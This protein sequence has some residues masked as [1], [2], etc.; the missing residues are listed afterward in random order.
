[1]DRPVLC[2]PG[3]PGLAAATLEEL[4]ALPL[5]RQL[6]L[7]E[8]R[9]EGLGIDGHARDLERVRRNLGTRVIDLLGHSYGSLVALTYAATHPEHVGR[10]VLVATATRLSEEQASL[11]RTELAAHA[12]EPWFEDALDA[13][14]RQGAGDYE[15]DEELAE[16]FARQ[17]PF[18]FANPGQAEA[19]F[20]ARISKLPMSA[21]AFRHFEQS[22]RATF[23]LR[24]LLTRVRARVLVVVGAQDPVLGPTSA[25][26][27]AD[28]IEGAWLEVIEDAGHFPWIEQ[29]QRFEE[30]VA[31]FLAEP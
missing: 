2:L 9:P 30:V 15:S 4:R 21:D 6:V 1:M 25:R 10:L 28:G 17:L 18:Y 24:P 5:G 14:Q 31:D 16:L 7:H 23:N 22:E 11:T 26:E 8:P 19:R 3:G 12:G 13:M 29:P 27:V 20:A